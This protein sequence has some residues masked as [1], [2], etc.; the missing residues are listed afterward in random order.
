[1]RASTAASVVLWALAAAHVLEALGLRRR[2]RKVTALPATA[3]AGHTG[4]PGQ[5]LE[6]VSVAGV[7]VDAGTLAGAANEMDLCGAQVL[8]LVPGDLPADRAI[9]LLR[10][11]SPT[12]LRDDAMYSPGGAH[13]VLVLHHTV[14]ARMAGSDGRALTPRRTTD[15]GVLVRRTVKAQRYAPTATALR[16][17]PSLRSSEWSPSDRWR[18]IEELHAYSLPGAKLAP[19]LVAAETAHLLAMT[20]GLLVSPV[21]GLVALVTWGAQPVVL[22][23][24]SGLRAC[25]FRFP[26][27]WVDNVRTALAGYRAARVAAA[28]RASEPVPA[29]PPVGE[30]FEPTRTTCAWCGSPSLAGRLD[31]PDMFQHKPGT[32]HLD[33]CA[34]CGH[35]FQNPA[36]SVRGLDHYYD[37]F[38]DGISEEQTEVVFASLGKAYRN[39][40]K[41]VAQFTEPQGW[42]DVGTG[43]GHFCLAARQQWPDAVID[44]LDMGESV[45]EA[46]R[47]GW[48]DTAYR[49][50]FLELAEGLP[51]SYDVVSMHHYLEH[52]REP[53]REL[54]AAAK[55]VEP[56]G[57]LMI[58]VPDP[59]SPWS[60]R[61]GRFWL[62]WM[63]PQH[64]HFI[65]CDNLVKALEEG[66]LEVVSVERGPATMG[67]DLSAAGVIGVENLAPSPHLPW[68]PPPSFAARV[69]RLAVIAVAAPL[70]GVAVLIDRVNDARIGADRV[71]N[72]Y[73]IVV[74]RS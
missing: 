62:P 11:V 48:I 35:I 36:L 33:Q 1:M 44:G 60:R 52:T 15:R 17:A 46:G 56:G 41:A 45:E 21:A 38:Y 61:L 69:K 16:L 3:G 32:F 12:Q 63:Q 13:E 37:Q 58:E 34:D 50:F 23:G 22:F 7:E 68:L 8:D 30:L 27:A 26:R 70:I 54:A 25:T 31:T 42:L 47:R 9:R 55:V 64:L 6:V 2:W 4:E 51:R 53:R 28:V 66:G 72:A 71:G 39:R 29:P 18:E 40:I 5:K 67:A 24:T 65:P 74:R 49:G 10:R 19:V 73:R 20:A 14:A 59:E 57:Y 43:H